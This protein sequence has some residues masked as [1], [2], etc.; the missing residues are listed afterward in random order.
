MLYYIRNKMN[1]NQVE[2]GKKEEIEM[3]LK[4]SGGSLKFLGKKIAKVEFT[5]AFVAEDVNLLKK[6]GLEFSYVEAGQ[7]GLTHAPNVIATYV[8]RHPDFVKEFRESS[9]KRNEE[10]RL[11]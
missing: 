8:F 7:D 3:L 4:G 5:A 11:L 1:Q 10:F 9:H 2:S 6:I